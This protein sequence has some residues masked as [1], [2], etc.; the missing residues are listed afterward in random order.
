MEIIWYVIALAILIWAA[1]M[2]LYQKRT[3]EE[4]I[5]PS[6]TSSDVYTSDQTIFSIFLSQFT[7]TFGDFESIEEIDPNDFATYFFALNTL[8]ISFLVMMNLI[9][10][11]ISDSVN[12]INDSRIRYNYYVLTENILEAENFVWWNQLL[13]DKPA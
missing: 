2:A 4:L 1:T 9:I 13:E 3:M 8:V 6:H 12:K 7:M 5:K 10:G 11:I